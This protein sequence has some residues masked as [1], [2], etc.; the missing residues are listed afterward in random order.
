MIPILF[1]YLKSG[2]E[3]HRCNSLR[4]T[5][6]GITEPALSKNSY[7]A[8]KFKFRQVQ[9]RIRVGKF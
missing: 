8:K 1:A 5:V 7:P 3:R 4:D 6:K 2:P 9:V